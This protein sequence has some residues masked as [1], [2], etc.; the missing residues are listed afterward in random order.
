MMGFDGTSIDGVFVVSTRA[1]CDERGDFVRAWCRTEFS[2]NGIAA[3]FCQSNLS[4]SRRRGTL[5]GLHFSVPP[6]AEAKLVRC[7]HGAVY[8]VALDLRPRSPTYRKWTAQELSHKNRLAL[9]IPEG[10][11][12]GFQTLADDTQLLYHMTQP[13]DP[14]CA[15]G[16]RWND[17]AFKISWPLDVTSISIRDR[18]YENFSDVVVG[19]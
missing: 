5:R 13:Y 8:D 16:V 12:H 9:F 17:P 3:E 10:V 4:T 14:T 2:D 1:V 19:Q 15:R 18:D 6:S 7:V 11:A